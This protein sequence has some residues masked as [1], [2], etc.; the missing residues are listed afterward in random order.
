MLAHQM[1]HWFA[2]FVLLESLESLID[3][4]H[5]FTHFNQADFVTVKG[6]A[7]LTNRNL[8][9]VLLIAAVGVVAA[10]IPVHTGTTQVDDELA[11]PGVP[12]VRVDGFCAGQADEGVG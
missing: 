2:M 6:I 5:R 9:A 11:Q 7:I 8:E 12:V 10:Q 1:M 4:L 3:N